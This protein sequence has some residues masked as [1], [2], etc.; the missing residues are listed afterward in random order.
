M[1]LFLYL[2]LMLPM[3]WWSLLLPLLLLPSLATPLL[4]SSSSAM[5][6]LISSLTDLSCCPMKVSTT[7]LWRTRTREGRTSTC[8]STARLMKT[9]GCVSD[10]EYL[11][12][13]GHVR[14]L[15]DVDP[16]EG[17][18]AGAAELLGQ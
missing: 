14:A 8:R 13:L 5:N 1:A 17:G 10:Q 6:L 18:A 12:V 2:S 11:V 9:L 16:Q 15:V 7:S 3:T 4:P